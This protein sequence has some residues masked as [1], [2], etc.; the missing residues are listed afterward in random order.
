MYQHKYISKILNDLDKYQCELS[1]LDEKYYFVHQIESLNEI[2]LNNFKHCFEKKM[3]IY[4]EYKEYVYNIDQKKSSLIPNLCTESIVIYPISLK[5]K[6]K[7][8]KHRNYIIINHEMKEIEHYEPHGAGEMYPY[9]SL[10]LS[11]IFGKKFPNY[12]FISNLQF[13]P[14]S[15]PQA[16]GGGG[17][18][19]LYGLL[20]VLI[21]IQEPYLSRKEIID[22][23]MKGDREQINY[24]MSK[25]ICYCYDLVIDN[26]L[27]LYQELINHIEKIIKNV[28]HSLDILTIKHSKNIY[29][30]FGWKWE[31]VYLNKILNR[32]KTISDL[33][34]I[35][36]IVN[37]VNSQVNKWLEDSSNLIIENENLEEFVFN[38][39][40]G[41][42]DIS[43]L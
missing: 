41:I 2:L 10:F 11:E 24:M 18:C 6:G 25:F 29:M 27:Y 43:K 12:N 32:F 40:T 38:S 28:L 15:G 39:L 1:Y 37:I 34:Y 22:D 9:V 35:L 23:T 17:W 4:L 21:R 8:I 7:K 31:F 33:E 26:K 3:T 19:V 42:R 14:F 13:C 16:V 20:Y 36:R 5:T 30:M